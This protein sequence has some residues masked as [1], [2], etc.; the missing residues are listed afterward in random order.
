MYRYR[1]FAVPRVSSGD[2]PPACS[3]M[4]ERSNELTDILSKI[5]KTLLYLVED[6]ILVPGKVEE[7]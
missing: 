3:G 7:V 4:G 1:Y 6:A 2:S 5:A